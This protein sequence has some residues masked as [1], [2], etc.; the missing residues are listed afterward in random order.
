MARRTAHASFVRWRTDRRDAAPQNAPA[1]RVASDRLWCRRLPKVFNMYQRILVPIDGSPNAAHG[2]QLALDLARDQRQQPR[3]TL[4]HVVDDLSMLL[5]MSTVAHY[6]ELLEGLRRYGQALLDKSKALASSLGIEAEAVLR[7]VSQGRIADV[8]LEE[9]RHACCDLVVMGTHGRRGGS[10]IAIG[11]D[12]EQVVR[13]SP[14]PVLL[15]RHEEPLQASFLSGFQR[16][17]HA[18]SKAAVPMQ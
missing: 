14:V 8:I 9:A 15:A 4:L 6:R 12:A 18:Y 2:L 11:S 13:T 3:L 10:R 17:A 5:E 1:C 16:Q 7:E